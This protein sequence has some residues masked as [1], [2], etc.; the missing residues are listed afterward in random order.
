MRSSAPPHKPTSA[1]TNLSYLGGKIPQGF[2]NQ[3]FYKF[4]RSSISKNIVFTDKGTNEVGQLVDASGQT[5]PSIH[6]I[7][8]KKEKV[9]E[10][11]ANAIRDLLKLRF[12][13]GQKNSEK[14]D[15]F[16]YGPNPGKQARKC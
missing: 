13:C 12:M 8:D 9:T 4:R 2:E 10:P 3:D 16:L 7:E 1:E 6:K 15:S 11:S 14:I 5:K